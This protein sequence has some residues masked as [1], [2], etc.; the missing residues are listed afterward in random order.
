MSYEA[1]MLETYN[2]PNQREVEI[3]LLKSLFLKGGI[4]KEFGT[5]EKM[6]EDLAN[7]FNLDERQR[8]VFLE[9]IYRK[10]NRLK[11]SNLWH[12]LLFRSANSLANK[13]LITRP[14][15]TEMITNKREWMLTE[16]GYDRVLKIL[17]ISNNE[18]EKLTIKTFEVQKHAN[19]ISSLKMP[20]N[21]NPFGE[22]KVSLI[23]KES[24]IR[25]RG[26]R[27][28]ILNSYDFG[29]ALCG[30][31]LFSPKGNRWEVEAAHIIPH[32]LNGKD[33]IWNGISL[34]RLHHWAFDAGWF[35]IDNK[36]RILPSSK[37]ETLSKYFSNPS[38][39]EFVKQ[40]SDGRFKLTLPKNKNHHPHPIAIKWHNEHVF[41][42]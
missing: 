3:S 23:S 31:R 7:E 2:M 26:F 1:K 28:A 14:K 39:Y 24:R 22:K 41:F 9:T 8:S 20:L 29:C 5:K 21:Y 38:N 11:K 32:S 6:V 10:E 42:K 19:K 12:R 34:C 30:L 15:Q 18:K 37:I 35:T 13:Q 40:I 17:N 25:Y 36:F 4:V 33:D 16:K 27:L